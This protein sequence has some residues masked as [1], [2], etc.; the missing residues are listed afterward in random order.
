MS[1]ILDGLCYL[2]S[3]GLTHQSLSCGG[4]LLGT[5]GRVK[6]ACLDQCSECSPTETYTIYANTIPRITM[7]LMQ[8]H[9]K[10]V[11]IAG[12]NDLNQWPVD[13]DAF[14]FLSAASTEPIESLRKHPLVAARNQPTEDLVMLARAVLCAWVSKMHITLAII[15]SGHEYVYIHCVPPVAIFLFRDYHVRLAVHYLGSLE[16]SHYIVNKWNRTINDLCTQ[17]TKWSLV[18]ANN[19]VLEEI[20]RRD[21]ILRRNPE[22]SQRSAGS[23]FPLESAEEPAISTPPQVDAGSLDG[24]AIETQRT[25]AQASASKRGA[26]T[27]NFLKHKAWPAEVLKRLPLWFEDQVRKNQSQEE[28]MQSVAPSMLSVVSIRLV[29]GKR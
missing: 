12:V 13:S 14:G 10:D 11:G 29:D 20:L 21:R 7:A 23:P 8:K 25:D 19:T 28:L 16:Q 27:R 1:Q 6:I 18:K 17:V 2:S 22:Q 9:E 3:F 5:N 24:M 15:P 4:I 26:G